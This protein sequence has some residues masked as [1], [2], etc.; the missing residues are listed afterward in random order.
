MHRK[1]T[2][3]KNLLNETLHSRFVSGFEKRKSQQGACREALG[4]VLHQ[5]HIHEVLESLRG[6]RQVLCGYFAVAPVVHLCAEVVVDEVE[7][8]MRYNSNWLCCARSR[9]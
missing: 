2:S 6:L 4:W 8:E 1:D 5:T 3:R 7:L 9:L